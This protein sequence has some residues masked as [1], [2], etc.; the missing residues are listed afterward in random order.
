M[1]LVYALAI[2]LVVSGL[3]LAEDFPPFRIGMEAI[4]HCEVGAEYGK[5]LPAQT[6]PTQPGGNS[7]CRVDGGYA[8][9]QELLR[10]VRAGCSE[11]KQA[12]H[13]KN[14]RIKAGMDALKNA[15]WDMSRV[16]KGNPVPGFAGV[17]VTCSEETTA[18]YSNVTNNM[19]K[20]MNIPE[21]K[22]ILDPGEAPKWQLEGEG[23]TLHWVQYLPKDPP[24]GFGSG[25][26][27]RLILPVQLFW[28]W[29]PLPFKDKEKEFKNYS[30]Q[31]AMDNDWDDV[32]SFDAQLGLEFRIDERWLARL[33]AGAGV[34]HVLTTDPG[35]TDR[36]QHNFWGP[37]ALVEVGYSWQQTDWWL[38]LGSQYSAFRLSE[39][40]KAS[41]GGFTAPHIGVGYGSLF[42]KAGYFLHWY[43]VN[44]GNSDVKLGGG[45]A[46]MIGLEPIYP[47]I[48]E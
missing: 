18:S 29:Y 19:A 43:Q 17:I 44:P 30:D 45:F 46:A 36:S 4:H 27:V 11:P 37:R 1:V 6:I 40:F 21:T 24:S 32:Q 39:S 25:I 8:V 48:T 20:A 28:G 41:E 35:V 33:A 3:V 26:N 12:V 5:L 23:E 7:L 10:L 9:G 13:V 42:L 14:E 15:G 34:A 47:S 2:S 31:E 16:I 22:K 38:V